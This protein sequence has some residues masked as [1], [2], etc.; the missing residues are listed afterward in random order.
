MVK[1]AEELFDKLKHAHLGGSHFDLERCEQMLPVIQEIEELK[2]KHQAVLLAHS[3][4]TPDILHTVADYVGDSYGLSVKAQQSKA[5]MIVFAAVDFMAETA[6]ILNP[7]KTVIAPNTNGGCSLAESI[8][9]AEVRALKEQYPDYTFMCYINTTADV[10]AECDLSVTSSNVYGIVEALE[11]DKIFF[12]PDRLMAHNI[13]NH[14]HSRGIR[15]DLKWTEG[16][17]YVHEQYEGRSIDELRQQVSGVKVLAHPECSPE[18]TAKA[19]YVGSTSG[20]LDYVKG[21]DAKAFFLLTECGLINRLEVETTGKRFV[22]SCMLCR[23]MKGNSLFGIRDALR[24]PHQYEVTL[25]DSVRERAL[26]NI[27]AM[28]VYT[29]RA[30][31]MGLLS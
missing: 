4:L 5:K 29:D 31:G 14:M 9:A 23:Y 10:K 30:R 12:L 13:L 15:K 28:F 22:G 26:K 21:S 11:N 17:C 16:T 19:D 8:T 2:A 24:Q 6:K 20:M 1:T 7:G 27:E 25:E 3:Y 18:V